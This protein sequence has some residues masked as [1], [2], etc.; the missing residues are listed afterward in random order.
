VLGCPLFWGIYDTECIRLK[1]K[2]D[3]VGE[4]KSTST[5]AATS[6]LNS[7]PHRFQ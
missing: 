6:V 1:I 2:C 5:S 4:T 3:D 7:E